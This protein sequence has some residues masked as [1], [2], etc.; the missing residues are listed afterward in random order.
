MKF[1][2]DQDVYVSTIDF[3]VS[4]GHDVVRASQLGMARSA[5]EHLLQEAQQQS[6]IFVTRDRD[7][8][9]LVFVRELESGVLY[10]RVLPSTQGVIH[11]EIRSILATYSEDVLIRSFVVVEPGGHRIRNHSGTD[12]MS[13]ND[14]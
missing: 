4:L 2:A 3:L 13:A 8:G 6:R 1:L 5:D 11:N 14:K 9:A 12:E 7:F 10:L